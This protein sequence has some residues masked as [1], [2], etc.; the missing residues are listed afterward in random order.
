MALGTAL[1]RP[2]ERSVAALSSKTDL[3]KKV[4]ECVSV[5]VCVCVWLCV[6]VCVAVCVFVCVWRQRGV[7]SRARA[8]EGGRERGRKR[9]GDNERES[10]IT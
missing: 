6:C 7:C 10:E 2:Q 5:C 8:R 1:I 3:L 4:C 9:M